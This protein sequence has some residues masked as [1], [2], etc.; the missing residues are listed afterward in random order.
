MGSLSAFLVC[1]C[2]A[3]A[4][5]PASTPSPAPGDHIKEPGDHIKVPRDHIRAP[6]EHI[7][8]PGDHIKVPGDHIK[9]PATTLP[10]KPK[11]TS[12]PKKIP[13][14]PEGFSFKSEM[15]QPRSEKLPLNLLRTSEQWFNGESKLTRVDV[16]PLGGAGL[17]DLWRD[18]FG[19]NPLSVVHDFNTGHAYVMDKVVGNCS[20]T[21]I[22]LGLDDAKDPDPKKHH[23][24]RMLNA[25]EFFDLGAHFEY[26]GRDHVGEVEVDVW[27]AVRTDW[28]PMEDNKLI[29]TTSWWTWK[30][31]VDEWIELSDN[32]EN[33]DAD[34]IPYQL[35]LGFDM[36][37]G[38]MSVDQFNYTFNY[39]DFTTSAPLDWDFDIKPCW[40]Q[41]PNRAMLA[42][43]FPSHEADIIAD[44]VPKVKEMILFSVR[45][46]GYIPTPV[47][48]SEPQL[49]FKKDD[50]D[51][52]EVVCIVE[53]LGFPP[54]EGDVKPTEQMQTPLEES[55][56]SIIDMIEANLFTIVIAD[57]EHPDQTKAKVKA[58]HGWYRITG[59][60]G[61]GGGSYGGH[62]PCHA[63][64]IDPSQ[65]TSNLPKLPDKFQTEIELK[66]H[67]SGEMIRFVEYYDYEHNHAKID[68]IRNGTAITLI[69]D[70]DND[71]VLEIMGDPDNLGCI[72]VPPGESKWMNL[73]L[74]FGDGGHDPSHK[75]ISSVKTMFEFANDF[76]E[77]RLPNER[78]RDI[79]AEHYLSCVHHVERMNITASIDWWFS[80]TQETMPIGPAMPRIPLKM[81]MQG[82]S[83]N[84]KT[85][86]PID[87]TYTFVDFIPYGQGVMEDETDL[88][89][90]PPGVFCINKQDL[91]K[92]NPPTT[93]AAFSYKA[94][95]TQPSSPIDGR[96]LVKNIESFYDARSKLTR[97]DH[98]SIAGEPDIEVAPST[99]GNFRDVHDFNTGIAYQQNLATGECKIM[100]IH[101]SIEDSKESM[102]EHG[103]K[104]VHM[105]NA[106]EFF[107][108][109]GKYQ[110]VGKRKDENGVL[111]DVW[112]TVKT[113][114]PYPEHVGEDTTNYI[115][116]LEWSF[117][118][119]AW[120][121]TTDNSQNVNSTSVPYHLY[122][123]IDMQDNHI[124]GTDVV[125]KYDYNIYDFT[126]SPPH[127]TAFDISLCYD[128][129]EKAH[130][131][132]GFP[133]SHKEF[134]WGNIPVVKDWMLLSI[135]IWGEIETHLRISNIEF[136]FV[137]EN[138]T[139]GQNA[140]VI[141]LFTLLDVAPVK[142]DP[143]HILE[144][145]PLKW[146]AKR[147]EWAVD[148]G[149]FNVLIPNPDKPDQTG[150]VLTAIPKSFYEVK[151][152]DVSLEQR[153]GP[154]GP[155]I[156]TAGEMAGIGIGVAILGLLIGLVVGMFFFKGSDD[157]L[158]MA[159]AFRKDTGHG[160]RV[161]IMDN[162]Q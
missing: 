63:K 73:I 18:D 132:I 8:V 123:K 72:A 103:F 13:V 40:D 157:G 78:V 150:T 112:I 49:I 76:K 15:V 100:P 65:Q 99:T 158:P 140:T 147:L 19:T 159:F 149:Q 74:P 128:Q 48:V 126:P 92:R 17:N 120:I 21:P 107:H 37:V 125:W 58:Q 88:Y 143:D 24:V 4:L 11:T 56:K 34:D 26:K 53:V 148:N 95:I 43:T 86:I 25:S 36:Q 90:S 41:F 97:L 44:N 101:N 104:M 142:G 81:H 87:L 38:K 94:Q 7:K 5:L 110:Y 131:V 160:D 9:A 2:V 127:W 62:Y 22:K 1:V 16:K 75:H 83:T 161:K 85:S 79:N 28:P 156:Y 70:Y 146:V 124:A 54:I 109:N 115:T 113:D 108:L 3:S 145:K 20:I 14:V 29:T 141:V 67:K 129:F 98:R 134:V 117:L 153:Y 82:V 42:F 116:T 84:G 135:G 136:D 71:Q 50:W 60:H 6:G 130:F 122:M 55:M 35:E 121:E 59:E 47:R 12:G 102:D 10:P 118:D 66:D 91:A 52:E 61:G 51:V 105:L 138:K 133:G 27:T 80:S 152:W 96:N 77:I 137:A 45:A 119:P 154:K 93:P 151:R 23:W 106:T 46:F 33:T 139:E 144:Q 31:L 69:Y 155:E 111:M 39:Y 89:E 162:E 57:P 32:E 114:W 64:K 30:F 68:M